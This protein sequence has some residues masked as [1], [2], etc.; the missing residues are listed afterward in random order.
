VWI[1]KPVCL[2]RDHRDEEDE[3]DARDEQ[4]KFQDVRK[5]AVIEARIA[6]MFRGGYLHHQA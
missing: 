6:I 1:N 5:T 3:K 2:K 4:Q